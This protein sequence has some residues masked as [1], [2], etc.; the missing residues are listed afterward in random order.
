[1]ITTQTE[2]DTFT[3][4]EVNALLKEI[5]MQGREV[6]DLEKERDELLVEIEER[7]VYRR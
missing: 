4:D 5:G 6:S 7:K 1:M 3:E 2:E